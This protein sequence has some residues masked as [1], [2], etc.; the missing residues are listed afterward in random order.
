MQ[1]AAAS[2]GRICT[3]WLPTCWRV[4]LHQRKTVSSTLKYSTRHTRAILHPY[5]G[6]QIAHMMTVKF[7]APPG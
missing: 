2:H 4:R 3:P 7:D 6:K 5:I 1:I